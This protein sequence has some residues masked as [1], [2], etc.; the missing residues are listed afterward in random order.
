MNK[1]CVF[2]PFKFETVGLKITSQMLRKG[3]TFIDSWL[4]WITS[5]WKK[6]A[7]DRDRRQEAPITALKERFR[8]NKTSR[9]PLSSRMKSN[10]AIK[11][12][13]LKSHMLRELQSWGVQLLPAEW[14][15]SQTPPRVPR[16]RRAPSARWSWRRRLKKQK[17]DGTESF[18]VK[19][20]RHTARDGASV[21][22]HAARCKHVKTEA[23]R[24]W[25]DGEETGGGEI[26]FCQCWITSR[27]EG[28]EEEEV[29]TVK[30]AKYNT[31]W[32]M[33]QWKRH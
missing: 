10:H 31:Q 16:H 17:Q 2:E 22:R 30:R 1:S 6:E 19:R 20:Q 11:Q 33:V 27:S 24:A 23:R 26:H 13:P 9:T 4:C 29:S 18:E 5:N 8:S 25:W 14:P 28:M 12:H 15:K 3:A 7:C 32:K 21:A